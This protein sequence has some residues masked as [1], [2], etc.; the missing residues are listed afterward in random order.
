MPQQ[1]TIVI[2]PEGDVN[3]CAGGQCYRR[4]ARLNFVRFYTR[5]GWSSTRSLSLPA[6]ALPNCHLPR[7]ARGAHQH[8]GRY[9]MLDAGER[10]TAR[11]RERIYISRRPTEFLYRLDGT[12]PKTKR[13][14]S[15]QLSGT[16]SRGRM[17]A[18]GKTNNS[19]RRQREEGEGECSPMRACVDLSRQ[20]Q[21]NGKKNPREKAMDRSRVSAKFR[22]G[23]GSRDYRL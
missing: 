1:K 15:C 2:P 11:F 5:I 12:D 6:P 7:V 14:L 19:K 3:F 16:K 21:R 20:Q 9:P 13:P 18:G 10:P 4:R 22:G 17:L 8:L 23:S